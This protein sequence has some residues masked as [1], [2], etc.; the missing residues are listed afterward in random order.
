MSKPRVRWWG[1]VRNILYSY[2]SIS[3]AKSPSEEDRRECDAVEAASR[4]TAELPD[5]AER[6]ELIRLVF[7]TRS[8]TL[9]GAALR[10]HLSYTTARRKQS[11]FLRCVGKHLGLR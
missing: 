2:P 6:M 3:R 11:E 5:G 7:F 4:E 1:F 10:L 8:C 9:E